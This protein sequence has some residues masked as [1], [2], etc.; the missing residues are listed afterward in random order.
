MSTLLAR[1]LAALSLIGLT[2]IPG[3][4]QQFRIDTVAGQPEPVNVPPTNT[5]L[6]APQGLAFDAQGN[7]YIVQVNDD[8]LEHGKRRDRQHQ[9][10]C[11][12]RYYLCFLR[13]LAASASGAAFQAPRYVAIDPAG[14]IF[15]TEIIGC[16]VDAHRRRDQSRHGL[17]GHYW[18]VRVLRARECRPPVRSSAAI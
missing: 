15:L 14:N 4:A 17:R 16:T 12:N 9:H 1:G 18:L 5:F 6:R 10:L 13:A 2:A 7:L 8:I 3:I 11:R